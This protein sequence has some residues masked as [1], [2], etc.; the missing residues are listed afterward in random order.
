[1]HAAL[2][3]GGVAKLG[4]G[5]SFSRK[6]ALGVTIAKCRVSK[7]MGIPLSRGGRRM[8]LGK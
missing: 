7:A 5:L 3:A 8:K 6:R 1:M 4:P 2:G